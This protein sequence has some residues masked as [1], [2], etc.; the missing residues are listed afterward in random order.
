[1]QKFDD[2]AS[3]HRA[4]AQAATDLRRSGHWRETVDAIPLPAAAFDGEYRCLSA[5]DAFL[6]LYGLQRRSLASHVD[7]DAIG[8]ERALHLRRA[9]LDAL[10]GREGEVSLAQA[11]GSTCWYAVHA[12]NCP[13]DTQTVLTILSERTALRRA[14]AG[15]QAATQRFL[16]LAKL[17][18]A[19]YWEQD[20]HLR[21]VS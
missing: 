18:P 13:T 4:E 17:S 6:A 3:G 7:A 11:D 14:E 10:S 8:S 9:I 21:F 2:D 12:S 19:W 16:T 20:E 5:N 1:M 15:L